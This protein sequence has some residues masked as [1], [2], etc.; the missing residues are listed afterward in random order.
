M[1]PTGEG[2]EGGEGG[3]D[4][5]GS[6]CR[7][8]HLEAFKPCFSW[9][10]T[11]TQLHHTTLMDSSPLVSHRVA[12]CSITFSPE[13]PLFSLNCF[14]TAA[15]K[16]FTWTSLAEAQEHALCTVNL[17]PARFNAFSEQL[18]GS[19]MCTPL[20]SDWTCQI[21]P[22]SVKQRHS[23]DTAETHS[24]VFVMEK[25]ETLSCGSINRK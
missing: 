12:S 21:C 3:A 13:Q 24:S 5:Y 15:L 20:S 6:R 2:G 7:F 8:H 11:F 9:A 1:L 25:A 10:G 4:V 14:Q 22:A 17:F 19:S 16:R 18:A 23:R